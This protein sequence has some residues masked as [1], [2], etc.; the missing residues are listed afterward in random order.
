MS[1]A[2]GKHALAVCDRCGQDC[3]YLDLQEE[4]IR[5]I[6]QNNNICPS[7]YDPDHPQNWYGSDTFVD[8]EGLED[9]NPEAFDEVRSLSGWNPVGAGGNVITASSGNASVAI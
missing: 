4:F 2:S 7:C 3:R 8:H 6:A 5:G 1:F 9:P